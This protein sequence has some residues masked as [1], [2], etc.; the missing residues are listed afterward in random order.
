LNNVDLKIIRLL[1]EI[2]WMSSAEIAH[3][4]G[5]ILTGTSNCLVENLI[6]LMSGYLNI[7]H[8]LNES[9]WL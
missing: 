6:D 2:G 7:V 4:L 8:D 1:N 5:D 9:A 3:N